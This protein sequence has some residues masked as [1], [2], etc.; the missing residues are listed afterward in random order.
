MINK[1]ILKNKIDMM[2]ES[3]GLNN[4]DT[5]NIL[6]AVGES[7]LRE[8]LEN[9]D[10]IEDEIYYPVQSIPVL[11]KESKVDGEPSFMV[12]YDML[13][14]L[15][16]SEGIDELQAM[17]MVAE[18]NGISM[19]RFYLMI[20]SEDFFINEMKEAGSKGGANLKAKTTENIIKSIDDLKSKGIKL[21][22]KGKRKGKCKGGKCK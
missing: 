16:E 4:T 8:V 2:I 12:E 13:Y 22:K 7:E 9:V 15:M 1:N 3:A 10:T 18:C 17:K 21:T 14:K 11:V 6:T 5:E 20:E 19:D